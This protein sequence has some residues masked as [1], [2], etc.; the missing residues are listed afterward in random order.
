MRQKLEQTLNLLNRLDSQRI[1]LVSYVDPTHE[2]IMRQHGSISVRFTNLV[3]F[4][5]PVKHTGIL[6]PEDLQNLKS[7]IKYILDNP[8]AF[9]IKPIKGGYKVWEMGDISY[10]SNPRFLTRLN[11]YSVT[12]RILIW[13]ERIKNE[14]IKFLFRTL[15]KKFK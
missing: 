8:S 13:I 7:S 3:G 10:T 6:Y 15:D 14:E 9:F 11:F 2:I 12:N 4:L 5:I 1:T